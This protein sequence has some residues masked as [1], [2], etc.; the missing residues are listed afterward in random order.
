MTTNPMSDPWKKLAEADIK[1]RASEYGLPVTPEEVTAWVLEHTGRVEVIS[2]Y[3]WNEHGRPD[4]T[5]PIERA[6]C[7]WIQWV[8]KNDPSN[9]TVHKFLGSVCFVSAYGIICCAGIKYPDINSNDPTDCLVHYL[10]ER[11]MLRCLE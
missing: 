5:L 1:C 3:I 4:D 6:L 8:E 2:I 11:D 7:N 9:V 10:T